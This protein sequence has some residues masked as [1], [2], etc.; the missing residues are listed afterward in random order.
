MIFRDGREDGEA[1]EEDEPDE[2]HPAEFFVLALGHWEDVIISSLHLQIRP[3]G[4]VPPASLPA[5]LTSI[6]L[7]AIITRAPRNFNASLFIFGLPQPRS[8]TWPA[9]SLEKSRQ[10]RRRYG[11][12]LID[13]LIVQECADYSCDILVRVAFYCE[14]HFLH[15]CVGDFSGQFLEGG[16]DF[17]MLLQRLMPHYWDG[18][19]GREIVAVVFEDG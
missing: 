10:G 11:V 9:F 3:L 14:I 4:F 2:I 6:A 7:P 13:A 19:V 8:G 5:L 1:A 17:G 15:F 16:A 12:R 18:F